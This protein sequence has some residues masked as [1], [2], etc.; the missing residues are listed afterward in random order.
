MHDQQPHEI[1]NETAPPPLSGSPRIDRKRHREV[2]WFFLRTALHAGWHDIVL[3][4]PLLRW[5]RRDPLTRWCRIARRYRSLAA[6]LG[7]V[8]IKLGQFLSTRVDVLPLAITEELA[9]LQDEVPPSAI[10]AV[11]AQVEDDFGTSLSDLF[12]TFDREALGAASLAQ[13]HAATLPDGTPVVVKVLRPGIDVLVETDLRAIATAIRWLKLWPFVRK[14]VDL[15]ALADEFTNT[16]RAELDLRR[17]AQHA[18]RIAAAFVH[19]A[20]VR[21]P[22]IHHDFSSRRTLT[23]ENVS[24]LKINDQAALS[25]AG[26]DPR[27]LA[28]VLYRAFMQQFFVNHFVHADPHPGNIFVRPLAEGAAALPSDAVVG[29]G[30]PFEIALVDFG[31]VAEIPARLR[32]ALRKYVIAFGGRDAAGVIGAYRDMGILLPGADTEQLTEVV[33]TIFERFWGVEVGDLSGRVRAEASGFLGEFRQLLIETPVQVQ[34]EL[35]FAN[36]A[37]E[38]LVGLVT[39]LDPRFDI[40]EETVPFAKRL[41]S[42]DENAW[43]GR[44]RSEAS[45]LARLPGDAADVVTRA[46]RG[47]LVVKSALAPDTKRAVTRIERALDRLSLAVLAAALL[48]SGAVLDPT[49]GWPALVLTTTGGVVGGWA[50][51]RGWWG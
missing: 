20:Q 44:L 37:V 50:L 21:I 8:L 30:T 29:D 15:D 47:R 23:E 26:I 27:A 31:M 36:R 33:E 16:T 10:D 12:P 14:R 42:E 5:L 25:D 28:Q 2:L 51:I 49:S 17:E 18:E 3:R 22:T 35:L 9:G 45:R 1:D 6:R 7:G 39:T 4:L 24:G 32:S 43:F 41:A 46:R 11:I 48:I 34:V 40:W 19:D 13:V 38:L